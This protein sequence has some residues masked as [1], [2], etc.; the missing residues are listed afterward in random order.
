MPSIRANIL[1]IVMK[2]G[3][4]FNKSLSKTREDFEKFS[5]NVKIPK[6]V[7]VEKIDNQNIK[8]EL[9]TPQ[10][11]PD[12]EII[13]FLH[14]GG[15][16]LG[17]YDVTRNHVIRIAT[18]LNKRVFMLDYRVAPENPYPAGT[19]DSY[20]GYIWLLANG[21]NPE[22]IYFYGES[23]GC[24]LALNTLIRV[25]DKNE[26]L[27]K[28][29]FFS[30]PFLDATMSGSTIKS[31]ADKDPYYCDEEYYISNHYVADNDPGDPGISPLFA[32]LHDL[33]PFLVHGSGYDMLLCNSID[34]K[35]RIEEVS[36][37]I[38]LKIWDGLWHVFHVNADIIPEGKKAIKEF[39][40]FIEKV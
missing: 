2:K 13:Y 17:I 16:C 12:N 3:M 32:D 6:D 35:D 21:Y 7:M 27:P 33:P 30:S 31:N 22:K 40:R 9:V 24:G 8:G 19:D 10:N 28:C 5:T 23:A 15:Y 38:E 29:S 1:R 14:G 18:I 20:N 11:A 36:G 34:F 39:G 26:K 25:R 4:N 37:E